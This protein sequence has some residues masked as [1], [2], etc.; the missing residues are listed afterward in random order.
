MK[1]WISE[2]I[3]NLTSV[4]R[5]LFIAILVS[6]L[7][8]ILYFLSQNNSLIYTISDTNGV[9]PTGT[10]NVA[11]I[12]QIPDASAAN[13]TVDPSIPNAP[14][15]SVTVSPLPVAPAT[16]ITV[17]PQP[18]VPAASITVNPSLPDA[19]VASFTCD[20]YSGSAPLT[21]TFTNTSTGSVDS[22]AWDFN[23]DGTPDN[24]TDNTA[25]FIFDTPGTY[26][27]TLTVTNAGGSNSI[28]FIIMVS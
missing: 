10:P 2:R 21:V 16:S 3:R 19:P 15:A 4:K 8:I 6:F 26:N 9:T 20:L 1:L 11:V 23:G 25:T 13:I 12:E 14:T 18:D 28:T 5:F 22:L 7:F 27:A 17:S 24:T